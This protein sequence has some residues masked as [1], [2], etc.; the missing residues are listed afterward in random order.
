MAALTRLVPD[1]QQ[2]LDDADISPPTLEDRAPVGDDRLDPI[3][4]LCLLGLQP[5]DSSIRLLERADLAQLRRRWHLLSTE[6]GRLQDVAH[7]RRVPFH[8]HHHDSDVVASRTGRKNQPGEPA[9]LAIDLVHAIRRKPTV[10]HVEKAVSLVADTA[11]AGKLAQIAQRGELAAH[12]AHAVDL[13]LEI[14]LPRA[15]LL[16][17]LREPVDPGVHVVQVDLRDVRIRLRPVPRRSAGG[18]AARRLEASHAQELFDATA[19]LGERAAPLVDGGVVEPRARLRINV[20]EP[21]ELHRTKIEQPPRNPVGSIL[22]H[23][24]GEVHH[25]RGEHHR[26]SSIR[27][28]GSS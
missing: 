27:C 24:R 16:D 22:D 6:A 28:D 17:V 10:V 12:V 13:S 3:G 23:D 9:H 21:V 14:R 5:A 26:S 18:H 15:V 20:G 19:R 8:R 7:L 11:E 4:L 1:G 2:Q 25:L